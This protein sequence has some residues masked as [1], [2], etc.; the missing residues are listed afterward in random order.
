MKGTPCHNM[1]INGIKRKTLCFISVFAV[2]ISGIF[3]L[4][5]CSAA[6]SVYA[7]RIKTV[8]SPL[9][10]REE[11]STDSEILAAVD[12]NTYIHLVSKDGDWW[13]VE[14]EEGKY[15]WC[16]AEYIEAHNS[17]EMYVSDG[18]DALNVR[19]GNGMTYKITDVIY[20]GECVSVIKKYGDWSKILYEGTKTGYVYNEY[21][22]KM[23]NAA[24]SRI[25]L[26]AVLYKQTDPRWADEYL[27]ESD[28]TIAA[29]GC[30][31]SC[32][33]MS[34]SYMKNESIYPDEMENLL[35]YSYSGSL[36]WPYGYDTVTDDEAWAQQAYSELKNGKPVII[37]AAQE[38]G[39][40]HW[41]LIKGYD[42][43]ENTLEPER[44]TINDP[45]TASRQYLGELFDDY[46]YFLKIVYPSG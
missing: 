40:Q 34:E 14:Y 5:Q 4:P 22:C 44:F 43:N 30:T 9:N 27:G 36:Y 39:R 24:Y 20:S 8:S 12:R 11:K 10:V 46:P 42:G 15:G 26:D 35:S 38:S 7:G 41:V 1:Y 23:K 28:K 2:I 25:S 13:R 19:H 31:T 6:D 3:P 17:T 18:C 29:C 16:A 32:L 37:G 21:L 45:A 33:A